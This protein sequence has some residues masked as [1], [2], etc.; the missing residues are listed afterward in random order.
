MHSE[1]QNK[2]DVNS[3]DNR[4]LTFHKSHPLHFFACLFEECV[5]NNNYL[6]L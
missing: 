1:M 5:S 3:E 2:D 6:I 4:N